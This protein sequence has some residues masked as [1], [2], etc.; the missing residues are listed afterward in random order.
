MDGAKEVATPINSSQVLNPMNGSPSSSLN[1][2]VFSDSDWGD[3]LNGGCFTTAYK[4]YLGSNIITW[5][6]ARQKYVS[7][8]ATGVEHKALA[9]AA[10]EVALVQNLLTNLGITPTMPPALF[11]DN[12][13]ATYLC[14]NLVY[15]SHMKH[16]ALDYHFVRE[17]LADGSLKV[18]HINSH[19]QLADAL[20]KPLSRSP[21]PRLRSKIG[22]F[23]GSSIL[24]GVFRFKDKLNLKI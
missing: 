22:V 2:H 3:A 6:L 24:R 12:T 5:K 19:D 16:V 4:L 20:T 15:H 1:I 14:A 17:K 11:Y 13:G 23:D 7:R 18:L 8:S 21:F 10:S 9:N